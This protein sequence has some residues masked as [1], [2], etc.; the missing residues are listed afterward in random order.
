MTT[1]TKTANDNIRIFR[2]GDAPALSESKSMEMVNVTDVVEQGITELYNAGVENGQEVRTLFR[3][4]GMSLTY[5]WFK[6]GYPLALHKHNTDCLYYIIAGSIQLGHD[7]LGKGDGFFLAANT[8]YT[9]GIGDNGVE[10]LEFRSAEE[11]TIEFMTQ[12]PRYW[13][14]LAS[15]IA[16][17]QAD[18]DVARPPSEL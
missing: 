10:I 13:S 11:F 5:A 18:W 9:Y 2:A 14:K 6:K 8:S 17:A 3:G 7:T 16:E 4:C 1:S 12:N 15:R